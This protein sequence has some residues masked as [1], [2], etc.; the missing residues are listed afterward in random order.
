[1]P[2]GSRPCKWSY[3]VVMIKWREGWKP[4]ELGSCKACLE[5][6]GMSIPEV[7]PNTN[8]TLPLP[9]LLR[10]EKEQAGLVLESSTQCQLEFQ[11]TAPGCR[12]PETLSRL[13]M[14]QGLWMTVNIFSLNKSDIYPEISTLGG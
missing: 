7:Q 13:V 1:M 14:R 4:N 9:A 6:S 3:G 10:L 5:S 12:N 8:I 2:L 11:G